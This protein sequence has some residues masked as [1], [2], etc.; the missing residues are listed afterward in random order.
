MAHPPEDPVEVGVLPH[1][2]GKVGKNDTLE[3]LVPEDLKLQDAAVFMSY[4]YQPRRICSFAEA[5]AMFQFAKYMEVESHIDDILAAIILYARVPHRSELHTLAARYGCK[6]IEALT[7][8]P[9]DYMTSD[10]EL[11][12]TI[13][14]IGQCG[15]CPSGQVLLQHL[16]SILQKRA[17]LGKRTSDAAYCIRHFREDF[18]SG[19]LLFFTKSDANTF[20]E[21]REFSGFWELLRPYLIGLEAFVEM[22][23]LF[24]AVQDKRLPSLFSSLKFAERLE[25]ETLLYGGRECFT[26]M[27]VLPE[28]RSDMVVLGASLVDA[29]YF[30][31]EVVLEL[32]EQARP[33]K[34]K[35]HIRSDTQGHYYNQKQPIPICDAALVACLR[36][37]L[38]QQIVTKLVR[39]W[40][41]LDL[42]EAVRVELRQ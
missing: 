41:V 40:G 17:S 38:R 26:K 10:E 12:K 19:L 7:K 36:S 8:Q 23:K 34:G 32:I 14:R 24:A 2:S 16:E 35:T 3:L 9:G 39:D 1:V 31:A 15:N 20:S 11:H 13:T 6:K 18:F 42:S 27:V 21:S 37:S 28:M 22:G 25:T 5:V 29:G 30:Q 33:H 4:L